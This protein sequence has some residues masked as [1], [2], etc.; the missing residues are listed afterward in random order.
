MAKVL[1]QYERRDNKSG[2][3]WYGEEDS[4]EKTWEKQIVVYTKPVVRSRAECRAEF[5][6]MLA[7]GVYEDETSEQ[8]LVSNSFH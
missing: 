1:Q 8:Q 6:R 2:I 4:D 3:L 7:L 5:R